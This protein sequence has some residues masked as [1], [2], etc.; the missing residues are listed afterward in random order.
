MKTP[1]ILCALLTLILFGVL[2]FQKY[3]R[4]FD[5]M[6]N[7]VKQDKI[8]SLVLLGQGQNT[9]HKD[10]ETIQYLTRV[11]QTRSMKGPTMGKVYKAII[12]L[13]S[14][15]VITSGIY[16]PRRYKT[17]TVYCYYT[18]FGDPE[19]F[20]LELPE[21]LPASLEATLRALE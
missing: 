11:F 2:S 4:N 14:G 8:K 13:E 20:V 3:Q 7:E 15:R 1:I 6:I 10:L 21:P 16:I 19:L 9:E 12:T 17:V 18:F 5:Y